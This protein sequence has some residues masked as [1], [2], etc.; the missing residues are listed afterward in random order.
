M[1]YIV[2]PTDFSKTSLK[3]FNFAYQFAKTANCGIVVF[4]SYTPNN[5]QDVYNAINVD[6]YKGEAFPQFES[7]VKN[8]VEVV[9]HLEHGKFIEA[10]TNYIANTDKNICQI[11]MGNNNRSNFLELFV[12]A[13]TIKVMEKVNKPVIAVPENSS[14]DG[15]LNDILFVVDYTE[16]EK[17]ALQQ[18]TNELSSFNINFHIVHFDV[19]HDESINHSM[20]QFKT[21]INTT[22]NMSFNVI[23]SID[24]KASITDYC[25]TNNIDMVCV[26]NKKQNFYQRLFNQRLAD[27]LIEKVNVPIMAINI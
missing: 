22:A 4:N 25:T 5:T 26:T 8:D 7:L 17:L 23:D 10:L 1:Q 21:S 12:K 27:E 9:Y 16:D 20:E 13:Q 14:F 2:F 19:Q 18:L 3:A 24:I 15:N 11:I 6:D